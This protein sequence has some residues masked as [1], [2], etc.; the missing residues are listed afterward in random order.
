MAWE[1]AGRLELLLN[2]ILLSEERRNALIQIENARELIG[3][4]Q[5]CFSIPS[6]IS[7]CLDMLIDPDHHPDHKEWTSTVLQGMSKKEKSWFKETEK[8]VGGFLNLDLLFPEHIFTTGADGITQDFLDVLH[9]QSQKEPEKRPIADFLEYFYLGYFEPLMKSRKNSIV[10]RIREGQSSLSFVN[11]AEFAASFSERIT[12]DQK[13]D[14]LTLS[15]KLKLELDG[16]A[17]KEFKIMVS[18]FSFPH[19]LVGYESNTH[20]YLAWDLPFNIERGKIYSIDALAGISEA[21]SDKSRLRI[22]LMLSSQPMGQKEIGQR[23][24][25]AKST[26]S[27]HLQILEQAGLIQV[28]KEGLRKNI[29]SVDPNTVKD[30]AAKVIDWIE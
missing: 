23:M 5:I 8:Q 11:P 4:T 9:I 10:T 17:L 20:F 28:V 21:L 18:L 12:Y 25:Y 27:K 15:K 30:F 26:I 13:K 22:L 24:G 29:I 14:R 2:A 6:E 1:R 19:L 3:K 7:L 16:K